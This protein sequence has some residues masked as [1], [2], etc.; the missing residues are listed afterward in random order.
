MELVSSK[1][2]LKDAYNNKYAIPAIN[3]SNME[4]T[5]AL[6][7]KASIL[8]SPI[9]VQV[10]PIQVQEQNISYELV[11][12]L[13]K[14]I[15][16]NYKGKYVI[17]LDHGDIVDCEKAI[18][19][20][21]NS[22]MYDGSKTSYEDNL[23]NSKK[24]SEDCLRNGVSFE[25]EL[26]ALLGSEGSADKEISQKSVFTDPNQARAFVCNTKVDT[27]AVAIGNAHGFYDSDPKLNFKLLEQIN[28]SVN[29]PLVLHGA[30]GIPED[31]IKKAIKSGVSKINFFTEVDYAYT[32]GFCNYVKE[33]K[34]AYMMSACEYARQKMMIEIERIIKMCESEGKI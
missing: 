10:A 31:D 20:G 15:A 28:K 21:F 6:L 33:N 18:S 7:E 12:K 27:L 17:H 16:K 32:H 24:I 30:S 13:I 25:A 5:M 1:E 22:I 11:T 3:V 4:T 29:I 23:S 9:I 26:G 19:A 8:H 14:L 34:D 2:L